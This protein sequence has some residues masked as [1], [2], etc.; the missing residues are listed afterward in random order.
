MALEKKIR[1]STGR[2]IACEENAPGVE[3]PLSLLAP[4]ISERKSFLDDDDDDEEI[5]RKIIAFYCFT[6][7]LL[8][9][10]GKKSKPLSFMSLFPRATS[11]ASLT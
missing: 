4:K 5:Q 11:G 9:D 1:L 2:L 10:C 6:S 7:A 3:A 8:S